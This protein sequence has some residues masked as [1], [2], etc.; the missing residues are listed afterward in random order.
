[1]TFLDFFYAL[2]DRRRRQE[3]VPIERRVHTP[4]SK[5]T[6]R[7]ANKRLDESITRLNAE[8]CKHDKVPHEFR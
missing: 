1:M 6:M 3:P 4:P 7:E 2:G 8:L 5:V